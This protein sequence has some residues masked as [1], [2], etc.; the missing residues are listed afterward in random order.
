[1]FLILTYFIKGYMTDLQFDWIGFN[2]ANDYVAMP[3]GG[4]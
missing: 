3:S 1:M 2:H 4:Q